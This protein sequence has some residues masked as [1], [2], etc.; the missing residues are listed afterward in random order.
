MAGGIDTGQ[1]RDLG[2]ILRDVRGN[3]S[4]AIL[5]IRVAG[6]RLA[7]PKGRLAATLGGTVRVPFR[8]FEAEFKLSEGEIAPYAQM[9]HDLDSGV[10]PVGPD[11][12]RWTVVDCGANVGLFSLFMGRA[13][14]I[15]AIEPNPSTNKRLSRNFERNGLNGT[16]IEA[17]V[18]NLDGRVKMDFSA[19]PSVLAQIGS[20]GTDIRCLSLDTIFE[21]QDVAAVDLLKL[22]VE[23]HELEALKGCAKALGRQ[24]IKQ[25]VAEHNNDSSLLTTLDCYL[26]KFGFQRTATGS[27][28]ARYELGA[29]GTK[30]PP[31][32]TSA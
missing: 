20:K 26:V 9:L 14:R 13:N 6:S 16:V 30:D 31:A 5:A 1:L 4:R 7:K 11:L 28:N 24:A 21:E 19:G 23:G 15:I 27:V 22:D 8:S 25:I 17:A 12:E 18:S 3:R 10:I 32:A 29:Q 2:R